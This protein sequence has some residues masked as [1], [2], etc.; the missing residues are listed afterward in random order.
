MATAIISTPWAGQLARPSDW[1]ACR[2][3]IQGG[4]RSFF[5]ASHLLPRLLRADAYALYGFCRLSDDLI[6][7]EGADM[8]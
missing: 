6:D 5:A 4:S 2:R 3:L 1:T 7:V 8:G